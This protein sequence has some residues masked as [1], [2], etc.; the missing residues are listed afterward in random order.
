MPWGVE[1][2]AEAGSGSSGTGEL[3]ACLSEKIGAL[4]GVRSVETALTP[5]QV[6]S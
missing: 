1:L 5:R 6:S 3:H 4:E 2:P